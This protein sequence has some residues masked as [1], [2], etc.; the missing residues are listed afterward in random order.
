MRPPPAPPLAA[1]NESG[2]RSAP[3]PA[4]AGDHERGGAITHARGTTAPATVSGASAASVEATGR[5]RIADYQS[6][7]RHRHAR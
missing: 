3:A 2:L 6:G 7:R 5:R 1:A 4:A